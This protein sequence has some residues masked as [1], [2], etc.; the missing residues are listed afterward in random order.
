MP[1]SLP[2]NP[3]D[4]AVAVNKIANPNFSGIWPLQAIQNIINVSLG[5]LGIVFFVLVLIGGWQWMTSGGD[6]KKIT[7]AKHRITTA[8]IGLAIILAS[9]I[10][11]RFVISKLGQVTGSMRL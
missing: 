4:G 2:S 8:V 7:D 9:L 1:D 11:A 6:E 10:I 3:W 5:L